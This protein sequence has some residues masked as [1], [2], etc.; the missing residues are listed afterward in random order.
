MESIK[1]VED[2]LRNKLAEAERKLAEAQS[3][4][5]Q[6]ERENEDL[7]EN[8]EQALEQ[9]QKLKDDLEDVRQ[10]SEKV[11]IYIFFFPTFSHQKKSHFFCGN[12]HLFSRSFFRKYKNGRLK[13]IRCDLSIKQLK[14]QIMH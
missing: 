13:C 11:S 9:I 14:P 12:F 5:N 4:E 7:K 1:L 2:E 10:D 3:R 8:Y 6:L